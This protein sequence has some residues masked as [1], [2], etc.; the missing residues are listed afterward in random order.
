[1]P[2]WRLQGNRLSITVHVKS[3]REAEELAEAFRTS[4]MVEYSCISAASAERKEPE[5]I[6]AVLTVL[7]R[8]SRAEEA[9]P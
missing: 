5:M 3:L 4:D 9:V 6:S 7:F 8:N 2:E 1:M